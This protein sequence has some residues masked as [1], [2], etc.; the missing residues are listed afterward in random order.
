MNDL[1]KNTRTQTLVDLGC[2]C[3]LIGLSLAKNFQKVIL[4]DIDLECVFIAQKNAW[5]NGIKNTEG[6]VSDRLSNLDPEID[7]WS[8]VANLPYLPISDKEFAERNNI[9][10]EPDLALYSGRD[11]LDLFYRLIL[12]LKNFENLPTTMCFEL[13]CRNVFTAQMFLYRNLPAYMSM[14]QFD[15]NGFDRFLECRLRLECSF[16]V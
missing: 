8:L 2:G 1:Y 14:V 10:H 16:G 7:N 4:V 11:G 5:K 15:V 3:G 12:E 6:L 9:S 13:D